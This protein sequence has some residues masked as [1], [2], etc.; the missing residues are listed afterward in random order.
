MFLLRRGT[1]KKVP[2]ES[3]PGQWIACPSDRVCL[4]TQHSAIGGSPRSRLVVPSAFCGCRAYCKEVRFDRATLTCRECLAKTALGFARRRGARHDPATGAAEIQGMPV[5]RYL[6]RGQR[7]PGGSPCRCVRYDQPPPPGSSPC[8]A[9]ASPT[10]SCTACSYSRTN[11]CKKTAD[12]AACHRCRQARVSAS[13]HRSAGRSRHHRELQ[14]V[15]VFVFFSLAALKH[16]NEPAAMARARDHWVTL[17]AI[18]LFSVAS[19][20][21]DCWVTK[22]CLARAERDCRTGRPSP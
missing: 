8:T 2:Q 16:L 21:T 22:P 10:S 4:Y 1:L 12:A 18:L 11:V 6:V 3:L 15:F 9:S 7:R 20:A 17:A 14:S 13:A 19:W 5:R